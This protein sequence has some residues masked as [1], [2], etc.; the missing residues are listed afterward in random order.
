MDAE[1]ILTAVPAAVIGL[2]VHE[3]AHAWVADR[4]GDPTPRAQGRL[5]LNPLRHIDPLG[6]L[7]IVLAGFGWAKPVQINRANLRRTHRDEI[8]ISLAGPF[9]NFL[10]AILLLLIAQFLSG[11]APAENAFGGFDPV[12]L[13]ITW[14]VLNVG[15][16]LFNLVPLPPLDGS[17]LYTTFLHDINPRLLLRIYQYG[18]AALLL[19]I[20]VQNNS[21]ITILPIA[22]M[23]RWVMRGLMGVMGLGIQ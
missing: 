7:L 15:L 19:I 9:S 6:F 4:L 13:C 1:W 17:H 14:S 12:T 18:T 5:T 2:T 3:F 11:R 8:L 21:H 16:F 10:L 20:L 22:P 23:V